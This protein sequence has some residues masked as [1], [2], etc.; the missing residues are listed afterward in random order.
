M[1]FNL[2]CLITFELD[3]IFLKLVFDFF[4][5]KTW[6]SD[7]DAIGK[8]GVG[9]LPSGSPRGIPRRVVMSTD[10]PTSERDGAWNTR[11]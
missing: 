9:V 4:L 10:S 2:P 8:Y 7:A 5:P 3:L 1:D 6:F 11:I